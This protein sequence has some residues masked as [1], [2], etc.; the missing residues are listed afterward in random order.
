M[1]G[2]PKPSVK[3]IETESGLNLGFFAGADLPY[4][5]DVTVTHGNRLP[6]SDDQLLHFNSESP[7]HSC[8]GAYLHLRLMTGSTSWFV[9]NSPSLIINLT[10]IYCTK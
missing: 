4:F 3:K 5:D 2:S 10:F 1:V 6:Y 9:S 8:L 7:P